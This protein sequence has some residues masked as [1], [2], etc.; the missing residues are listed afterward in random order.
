KE[1]S[2]L[3]LLDKPN[4]EIVLI[5]LTLY[6]ELVWTLLGVFSWDVRVGLYNLEGKT[7]IFFTLVALGLMLGMIAGTTLQISLLQ[8]IA[9]RGA[10]NHKRGFGHQGQRACFAGNRNRKEASCQ[11]KAASHGR[12]ICSC[13]G[14]NCDTPHAHGLWHNYH[15]GGYTWVQWCFS[16]NL[17][18]KLLESASSFLFS[19][20]FLLPAVVS[21]YVAVMRIA[22]K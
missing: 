10:V 6:F 7:L 9:T 5:S 3:G 15:S 18:S 11:N 8:S 20:H 19:T 21:Y 1:A 16:E 2:K 17:L 4:G 12:E 13:T 14:G 22:V